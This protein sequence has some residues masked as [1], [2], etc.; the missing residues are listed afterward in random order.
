MGPRGVTTGDDILEVGLDFRGLA[1]EK[2]CYHRGAKHL[3]AGLAPQWDNLRARLFF[4][5]VYQSETTT[6]FGK[7]STV[8]DYWVAHWKQKHEWNRKA[9][10]ADTSLLLSLTDYF[11]HFEYAD[12][13]S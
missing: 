2:G 5:N 7:L 6:F 8:R 10:D 1:H 4:H 12:A 9:G 11:T 13:T 3:W